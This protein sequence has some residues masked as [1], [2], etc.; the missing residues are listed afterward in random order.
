MGRDRGARPP[1]RR[2]AALVKAK[3][4]APLIAKIG[5][6][7]AAR[8]RL[9]G[10]DEGALQEH[11]SR[12]EIPAKMYQKVKHACFQARFLHHTFA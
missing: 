3:V 2:F 1:R 10:A 12:F 5:S 7:S 11:R 9:Y 4:D 6:G 8:R